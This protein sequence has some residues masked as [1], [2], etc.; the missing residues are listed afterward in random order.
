LQETISIKQNNI[1]TLVLID[2]VCIRHL[3][4][5][6]LTL[7]VLLNNLDTLMKSNHY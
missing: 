5:L 3:Y 4:L 1:K 2:L 7:Q 6:Y